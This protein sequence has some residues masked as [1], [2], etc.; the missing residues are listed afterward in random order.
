MQ[1]NV[2]TGKK[3]IGGIEPVEKNPPGQ[4]LLCDVGV[5]VNYKRYLR[6]Y[7]S[8]REKIPDSFTITPDE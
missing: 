8:A 6:V 4:K 7:H 5:D 1:R 3:D 2:A